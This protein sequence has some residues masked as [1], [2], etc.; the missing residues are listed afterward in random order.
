[1]QKVVLSEISLIYGEVK[2]P[3][4]FEIDRVKIKEEII[5]SFIKENRVSKNNK[6]YSYQDYKLPFSQN[7]QWLKDYIK[8]HFK[9]EYSFQ[10]VPKLDFGVILNPKEKSFLRNQVDPV[11]LRNSAD[12]TCIYVVESEKDSCELIIEYDDNRRKGRTWHVPLK[13][14]FYYIFPATQKYFISENKSKKINI[15]LTSTYEY[16]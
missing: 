11:D 5:S 16:I 8:D 1:M 2:T 9:A 6:D 13:N 4:G 10:L 7:L 14:N 3:K 12:Y 15:F